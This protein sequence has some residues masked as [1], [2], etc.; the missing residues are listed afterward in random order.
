ML[1]AM[2]L[3]CKQFPIASAAQRVHP[4]LASMPAMRDMAAPM[5]G[6]GRK[7][8]AT[9]WNTTSGRSCRGG[10]RQ[11][12]GMRGRKG[13][14]ASRA[15][16]CQ[17]RPE[18]SEWEAVSL[19]QLTCAI[20]AA[21]QMSRLPTSMKA[22]PRRSTAREAASMPGLVSELS[23]TSTPSG[24]SCARSAANSAGGQTGRAADR[25]GFGGKRSGR[26][27]AVAWPEQVLAASRN[28][29]VP[30][31]QHTCGP[32]VDCRL[33]PAPVAAQEGALGVAACG[34]QRHASQRS[35]HLHCSQAQAA[36]GCVDEHPL[37]GLHHCG[38]VEAGVGS[39]EDC[40]HGA[41]GVG[42]DVG[43]H[44]HHCR[45]GAGGEEEE[46]HTLR[47]RTASRQQLQMSIGRGPVPALEL[48][49]RAGQRGQHLCDVC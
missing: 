9:V 36:C 20:L 21:A 25:M 38:G 33:H 41:G 6:G 28:P 22:P 1:Y 43:R 2:Q 23:T 35:G 16:R 45:T 3:L 39:E 32:A 46:G 30:A 11:R 14:A 42:G 27:V 10:S 31:V 18:R 34:A 4:P 8:T 12:A 26:Q 5:T 7:S 40:G 37:A 17:W 24:H 44:G 47:V 29:A 48:P 15:L 49:K 13:Q 19:S